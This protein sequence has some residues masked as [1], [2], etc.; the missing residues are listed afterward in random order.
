MKR[1]MSAASVAAAERHLAEAVERDR[2]TAHSIVQRAEAVGMFGT[3]HH[4]DRED[5]GDPC[6]AWVN[7]DQE[8]E[9]FAASPGKQWD[10]EKQWLISEGDGFVFGLML[11]I[12]GI[13]L[14]RAAGDTTWHFLNVDYDADNKELLE[15]PVICRFPDLQ[16][17]ARRRIQER[18]KNAKSSDCAW[19]ALNRLRFENFLKT[20]LNWWQEHARSR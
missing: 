17:A 9:F 11:K 8:L 1:V 20:Y 13:W 15:H 14:S 10:K 16:A 7:D 18:G 19:P 5:A 3:W 12:L 6:V 2:E 4:R